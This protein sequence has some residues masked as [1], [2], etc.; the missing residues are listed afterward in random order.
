MTCPPLHLGH[1]GTELRGQGEAGVAEVVQVMPAE[2]TE[3]AISVT[4]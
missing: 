1:R 2:G 4:R 3:H